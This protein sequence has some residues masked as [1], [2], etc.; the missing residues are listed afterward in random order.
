[1]K[2]KLVIGALAVMLVGV[3]GSGGATAQTIDRSNG[4]VTIKFDLNLASG[5]VTATDHAFD[6]AVKTAWVSVP[7]GVPF[8]IYVESQDI[9]ST[10]AF[11]PDSVHIGL[12]TAPHLS[13]VAMS[14]LTASYGKRAMLLWS[15]GGPFYYIWSGMG[16]G[17]VSSRMGPQ[18]HYFQNAPGDTNWQTPDVAA[19]ALDTI[20]AAATSLKTFA[21]GDMYGGGAKVQNM[22]LL[23]FSLCMG[24]NDSTAD[25]AINM[26]CYIIYREDTPQKLHGGLLRD[27]VEYADRTIFSPWNKPNRPVRSR[28]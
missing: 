23:R 2:G 6:G 19:A 8:T 18:A 16:A 24:D 20:D 21:F 5:G 27:P 25:A 10:A 13:L 3:L 28:W 12:E 7:T 15:A 17:V 1:M 11:G 4:T 22:G 14:P 26:D 9:D